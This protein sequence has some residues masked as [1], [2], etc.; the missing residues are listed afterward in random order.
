MQLT[1]AYSGTLTRPISQLEIMFKFPYLALTHLNLHYLAQTR[2]NSPLPRGCQF[3]FLSYSQC[4]FTI[5][6]QTEDA[7]EYGFQTFKRQ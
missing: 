1:K 6:P 5:T 7:K 4:N 3:E 2:P